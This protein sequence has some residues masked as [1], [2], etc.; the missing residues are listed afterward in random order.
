MENFL[1]NSI[2]TEA[3]PLLLNQTVGRIFEPGSQEIALGLRRGDGC[4]L[5]ISLAPARPAIFITSQSLKSLDNDRP[6][7]YFASL[8]RKYLIGTTLNRFDKEFNER[9][10]RIDFAGFDITG[11]S[12]TLSLLIELTGR[13]S[14]AYL[15]VDN[16][17]L[18]SLRETKT[19]PTL[20]D[21]NSLSTASL[22]NRELT[23][24]QLLNNQ[25]FNDIN[26]ID[27]LA[28]QA[29]LYPT[30]KREL[31]ARSESTNLNKSWHSLKESLTARVQPIIYTPNCH[32]QSQLPVTW[33][34]GQMVAGKNLLLTSFPLQIAQ[35]L[36]ANHYQ[37]INEAADTYYYL[38]IQIEKFLARKNGLLNKLKTEQTRTIT[39][40]N[41]LSR[42]A[43]EFA[44]GDDYR[45]LG[46]L[47][48]ANLGTAKRI[49]DQLYIIDYY[50]DDQIEISVPIKEQQTP[51]QLAEDYFQ[52]YQRAR[53]GTEAV[54]ERIVE[55]AKTR[56]KRQRLIDRVEAMFTDSDLETILGPPPKPE[57]ARTKQK[58]PKEKISGLRRY[59]S[60]DGFEI[61]VGR[62]DASN[63]QLTFQ[64]A[65]SADIWFHAADYPGSHVLIRNP[66]RGVVPQK[67]I[68]EA[69][70]LAAFFSKAKGENSAA[71]RYTERRNVSRPKKAK[72]GMALLTTFKTVMVT[73][74]EAA[75]RVME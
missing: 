41:K 35:G 50:H 26:D 6:P 49:D 18:A 13:S 23:N 4:T 20:L 1:I 58:E 36:T 70:Q 10:L 9:R 52:K 31:I 11:K 32:L 37:S 7:G 3:A 60:A 21:L 57:K 66:A 54:K 17:Y 53:R 25:S 72:P 22:T 15:F 59:R 42:E 48:L 28:K 69:A 43:A 44:Q 63:D 5:F 39:L 55:T 67:T 27:Q 47:I 2:V 51:Q 56:D 61:L 46:E 40:Y 14:N 71:V 30:L 12:I 74:Q 75:T 16:A 34:L 19:I 33:P 62:S 68:F 73:P 8:L 65:K 29:G 64:I 45:K 38:L 24:N